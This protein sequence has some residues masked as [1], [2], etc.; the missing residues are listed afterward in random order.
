[1][2]VE[3]TPSKIPMIVEKIPIEDVIDL[4][5]LDI[6]CGVS[7]VVC[8]SKSTYSVTSNDCLHFLHFDLCAYH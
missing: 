7:T 5:I 3:I 1:M 4:G 2:A 6:L 8:G